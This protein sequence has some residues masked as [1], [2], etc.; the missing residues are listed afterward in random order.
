[1]KRINKDKIARIWSL[2]VF[3]LGRSKYRREIP[4]LSFQ[5]GEKYG[6]LFFGEYTNHDNQVKIWWKSHTTF[7]EITSTMIHEYVHYLQYWPWYVR[8]MN[9]YTY[10]KN[11]YEIEAVLI[12]NLHEPEISKYSGDREWNRLLKR[13]PR[14]KKIYETLSEQ[15]TINI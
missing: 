2:I 11:P 4:C 3:R 1:M 15:I 13:E 9:R 6:G 7:K 10:D 5:S 12:S 14:L 8:Y